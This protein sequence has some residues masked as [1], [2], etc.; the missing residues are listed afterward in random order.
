MNENDSFETGDMPLAALLAYC[1]YSIEAIDKS[2]HLRA[3]FTFGRDEKMAGIIQLYWRKQLK[4]EPI[5]YF[6]CIKEI[7]S[8][9][10][11]S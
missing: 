7:K 4:V 6:S 8:R 3:E 9:L 5:R 2:D 11:N 10:H 1:G